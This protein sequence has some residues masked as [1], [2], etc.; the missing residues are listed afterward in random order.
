MTG[1]FSPSTDT[2]KPGIGNRWSHNAKTPGRGY[3]RRASR[4]PIDYL[5]LPA[6]GPLASHTLA[7]ATIVVPAHNE[8]RVIGR[9]LSQ[10]LAEAQPGEFDIVV[11]ANGCTDDT[12]KVAASF[13]PAVRVIS[14]PVAS[15]SKALAAGNQAVDGFPR[16][17]VDADVELHT[18]DARALAE[19]LRQPGVLGAGP[20]MTNNLAD[21]PRLIRWYYAVWEQ[22]PVVQAGLFGRGVVGVSETGY[23]RIAGLPPLMG[24]DLA[25]SLAFG[26]EERVIV[27]D[28]NVTIHPPRTFRDLLRLRV[29][30]A[31]G[32]NE[33]E[34][35]DGT[36]SASARTRPADLLVLTG[37]NPLL[38]PKV[39]LFLSVTLLARS[40][41]HRIVAGSSYSIWLRDNSSRTAVHPNP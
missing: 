6:S 1:A 24:D 41:A 13:G 18:R 32:V 31:M 8:A 38:A 34:Q 27:Q 19:A 35:T 5:N 39:A 12:A 37:R 15:K 14:I 10:L 29:R 7:V 16:I 3:L 28:A 20:R 30:A 17:Y 21:S 22:L 33:I 25:A 23:K 9:L 36:P 4:Q 40:S 2:P 11:V 26:P